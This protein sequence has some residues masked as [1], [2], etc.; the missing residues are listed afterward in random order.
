M[1]YKIKRVLFLFPRCRLSYSKIVPPIYTHDASCYMDE[2]YGIIGM[3]FLKNDDKTVGEETSK[4]KG[5]SW[6]VVPTMQALSKTPLR[7]LMIP[8]KKLYVEEPYIFE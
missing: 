6:I 3:C 1:K 2:V 5:T 4:F 8:M 7:R